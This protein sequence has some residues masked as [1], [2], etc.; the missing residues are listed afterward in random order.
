MAVA[1]GGHSIGGK[2]DFET[3][4]F[5]ST[6]KSEAT[7]NLLAELDKTNCAVVDLSVQNRAG[8]KVTFKINMVV[9]DGEYAYQRSQKAIKKGPLKPDT[10]VVYDAFVSFAQGYKK[11]S[12]GVEPTKARQPKDSSTLQ[13]SKVKNSPL[14]VEQ[15]LPDKTAKAATPNYAISLKNLQCRC[16]VFKDMAITEYKE[17]VKQYKTSFNPESIETLSDNDLQQLAIRRYEFKTSQR[18]INSKAS[19]QPPIT[20]SRETQLKPTTKPEEPNW[21][22]MFKHAQGLSS[23]IRTYELVD[24][25]NAL[26]DQPEWVSTLSSKYQC[27]S[28]MPEVTER[29]K[30]H[31]AVRVSKAG[32]ADYKSIH[33]HAMVLYGSDFKECSLDC[34]ETV[35]KSR[36]DWCQKFIL[37][38]GALNIKQEVIE[39]VQVGKQKSRLPQAYS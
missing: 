29:V 4:T 39:A 21:L 11:S 17:F 5:T 15:K 16:D 36:P 25:K 35:L 2:V 27:Q 24:F 28:I 34:F 3:K 7:H 37:Q 14:Q 20:S 13:A 22:D 18:V 30:G 31:A 8:D 6:S 33:Q 26:Q 12:S 38:R 32:T 1:Q 9:K 19:L 10:V 23:A